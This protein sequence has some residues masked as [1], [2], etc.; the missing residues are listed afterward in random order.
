MN[1][2]FVWGNQAILDNIEVSAIPEP[3]SAALLG[4]LGTL[5]ML[6]RRRA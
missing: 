4:G 5:L 6:R 2:V 3:S 1:N